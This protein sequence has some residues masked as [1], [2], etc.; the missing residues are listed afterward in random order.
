M[1]IYSKGDKTYKAVEYSKG[2][3]GKKHRNWRTEYFGITKRAEEPLPDELI[4]L[5][6][7]TQ[8]NAFSSLFSNKF[9]YGYENDTTRDKEDEKS[10]VK[11]LDCWQTSVPLPKPFKVLDITDK[12]QRYRPKI[13]R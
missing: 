3:H 9:D 11:S 10:C 13:T 4:D 12:S 2:F 6:S 8:R 1:P 5:L 7:S